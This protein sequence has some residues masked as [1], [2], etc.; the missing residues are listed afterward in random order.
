M[1]TNFLNEVQKACEGLVW[2][3]QYRQTSHSNIGNDL[4]TYLQIRS[5]IMG[6]APFFTLIS[7]LYTPRG[8][9]QEKISVLQGAV[10][11]ATGLQNDL[12]GLEKDLR[13]GERMNAVMVVLGAETTHNIDPRELSDATTQIADIRNRTIDHVVLRTDTG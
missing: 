6:I 13:N 2:E 4:A 7:S 8:G 10:S 9:D 11:L 12:I 3:F 1:L 5:R